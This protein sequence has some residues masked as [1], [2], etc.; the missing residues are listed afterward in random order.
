MRTHSQ[1]A[2]AATA[3]ELSP[4]PPASLSSLPE[5]VLYHILKFVDENDDVRCRAISQSWAGLRRAWVVSRSRL[6]ANMGIWSTAVAFSPDGSSCHRRQGAR[7]QSSSTTMPRPVTCDAR[8]RGRRDKNWNG[9]HAWIWRSRRQHSACGGRQNLRLQYG[10]W[11]IERAL[12]R[13]RELT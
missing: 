2:N 9:D 10:N 13:T 1:R 7:C 3:R 5:D 8:S 11:R 4:M 6:A 12:A